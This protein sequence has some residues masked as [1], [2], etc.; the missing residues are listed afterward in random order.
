VS[1]QSPAC[2][3]CGKPMVWRTARRGRT[4]GSQFWGCPSFPACRGA[5][6]A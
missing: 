6:A 3:I 4:V 5:R 2:P 1:S